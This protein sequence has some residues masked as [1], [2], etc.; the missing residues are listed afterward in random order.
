MA[1]FDGSPAIFTRTQ[2]FTDVVGPYL[3]FNFLLLPLPL[4]Y[5]GAPFFVNALINLLLAEL[6]TN[7]HTFVIIM[8]NHTGSDMYRFN[9]PCDYK[10]PTFYLRQVISSVDYEAGNDFLDFLQG[11]LNYQIEHHIW[12]DLS[13]LAYRKAQ[14]QVKELCRKHGVP[15][16]QENVFVRLKKTIDVM[17]GN[18]SMRTFPEMLLLSS[19]R[20]G[21]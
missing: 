11:G 17:V 7:I 2:Y 19:R 14:P 5:F 21:Q 10:S 6:L 1:M 9:T 20:N 8:P 15:Y 3:I 4:L 13:L 18:A 16:V 12:P